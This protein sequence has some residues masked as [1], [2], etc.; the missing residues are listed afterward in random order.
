MEGT[1]EPTSLER[2]TDDIP[3]STIYLI[4]SRQ[5][6]GRLDRSTTRE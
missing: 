5:D 1:V 4:L 6:R 3:F 2:L